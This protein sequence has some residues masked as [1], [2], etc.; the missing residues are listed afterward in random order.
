[1]SRRN[2]LEGEDLLGRLRPPAIYGF[3]VYSEQWPVGHG[4]EGL[5]VVDRDSELVGGGQVGKLGPP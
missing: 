5:W 1:M 3:G 2:V 4:R